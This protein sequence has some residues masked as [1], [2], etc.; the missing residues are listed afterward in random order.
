M[1]DAGNLHMMEKGF[2]GGYSPDALVR[3]GDKDKIGRRDDEK[4][5]EEEDKLEVLKRLAPNLYKM[6]DFSDVP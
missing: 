6:F 4:E 2:A 3:G 1:K 5:P